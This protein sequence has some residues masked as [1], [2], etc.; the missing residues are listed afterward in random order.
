MNKD[1]VARIEHVVPDTLSTLLR[2]RDVRV[3]DDGAAVSSDWCVVGIEMSGEVAWEMTLAMPAATARRLTSELMSE[4]TSDGASE[5]SE[6]DVVDAAS[7]LLN[8]VAGRCRAVTDV[9]TWMGIPSVR[10]PL[11]LESSTAAVQRWFAWGHDVLCFSTRVLAP[12]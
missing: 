12:C 3:I 2:T 9:D 11:Q 6:D 1:V 8:I 4:L 10:L 5:V 7:E